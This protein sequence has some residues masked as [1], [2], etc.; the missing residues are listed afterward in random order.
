MN[1]SIETVSNHLNLSASLAYSLTDK[2]LHRCEENVSTRAALDALAKSTQTEGAYN[3]V[4][5]YGIIT[6]MANIIYDR[7]M[8]ASK[9]LDEIIVGKEDNS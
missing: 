2:Y 3:L 1:K 5:D 7:I 8:E 6:D 9:T 4:R